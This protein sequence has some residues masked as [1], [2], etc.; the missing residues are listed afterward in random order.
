MA[1]TILADF[2]RLFRTSKSTL[3]N[4]LSYEANPNDNVIIVEGRRKFHE[5]LLLAGMAEGYSAHHES[6]R[7]LDG[8]ED[9]WSEQGRPTETSTP[10]RGTLDRL[11]AYL[12]ARAVA[13]G[14]TRLGQWDRFSSCRMAEILRVDKIGREVRC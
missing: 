9:E 14:L 1:R 3:A 7:T 5:G 4:M 12:R 13:V 6:G 10:A 11:H 2:G 8:G